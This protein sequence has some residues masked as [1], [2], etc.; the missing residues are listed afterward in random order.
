MSCVKKIKRNF[1]T[2]S[3]ITI[4]L[5]PL[6]A[7][8]IDNVNGNIK[9]LNSQ[10]GLYVSGSYKVGFFDVED[11]LINETVF[12]GTQTK[13]KLQLSKDSKEVNPLRFRDHFKE[14]Y[15]PPVFDR[16]Y[17]NFTGAVGYLQ[18]NVR[19]EL[20]CSYEYSDV[21]D[22]DSYVVKDNRR[23]ISLVRGET[24]SNGIAGTNYIIAENKGIASV[25]L[26]FNMCYDIIPE[27]TYVIPYLCAGAGG[28]FINMFDTVKMKLN[29][30]GKIG[31]SYKIMSNVVAFVDGYYHGIADNKFDH[32]KV[33]VPD[34]LLSYPKASSSATANANIGYMGVN[35][36]VRFIL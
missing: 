16:S 25:S 36:G 2:V 4:M 1:L 32:L 30:Q 35:L 6:Q 21:Q 14:K 26:I 7:F 17:L 13:N 28:E 15:K 22:D 12:N 18:N 31:L 34:L 20:E 19:I 11:F 29:Y 5:L 3:L 27:Y 24:I 33:I 23:F 10:G 9:A 8:S